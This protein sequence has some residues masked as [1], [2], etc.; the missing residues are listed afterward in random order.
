LPGAAEIVWSEEPLMKVRIAYRWQWWQWCLASAVFVIIILASAFQTASAAESAWRTALAEGDR[1]MQ[2]KELLAAEVCFREALRDVRRS[3]TNSADDVVL[4]MQ[5]L[6][7]NLQTQDQFSESVPLYKKSLRLLQ[8]A[9]GKQSETTVPTLQ[10]LGD[11]YEND[12]Q[13]RLAAKYYREALAIVG[14]TSGQS[15]L[16]YAVLQHLLGIATFKGGF[17]AQA[18]KLYSSALNTTMQQTRL[19]STDILEDLLSDYIDLLRKTYPSD[20][21][22]LASSFQAELLKDRVDSFDRSKNTDEAGWNKKV[23]LRMFKSDGGEEQEKNKVDDTQMT[24]A[25]PPI[26]MD[27]RMPDSVALEQ[28]NKQRQDF[29]ER[30]VAIDEKTLGPQHPSVARDLTGLA[31]VFLSQKKY[32]QAR[33][34]VNRAL[35]IYRDSYGADPLVVKRTQLLLNLIDRGQPAANDAEPVKDYLATVPGI[36]SQAQNIEIALRLNYLGLLVYSE[37]K[38]DDAAKIYAWALAATA[39]SCGEQSMLAGTCLNDYS[40][41]LRSAGRQPEA[42][43]YEQA[44]HGIVSRAVAKEAAL[45]VP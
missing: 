45:L 23:S 11:I 14:A 34:V 6:A 43:Q 41:V 7:A 35:Q 29:Y 13:Y 5:R 36:P 12:S 2:T 44:A 30:M 18:E 42:E 25:P 40:R 39:R 26:V 24:E 16:K 19:P 37:G 32:D 28:I 21:R 15:S 31:Y 20:R 4:C 9:H 1:R 10:T 27:K 22:I 8:K 38:I 33:I 17:P 3:K